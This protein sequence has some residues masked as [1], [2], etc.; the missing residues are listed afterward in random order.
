MITVPEP[1]AEM[2]RAQHFQGN[3]CAPQGGIDAH[4]VHDLIELKLEVPSPE[5]RSAHHH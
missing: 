1:A 5:L 3:A 4:Q 2:V